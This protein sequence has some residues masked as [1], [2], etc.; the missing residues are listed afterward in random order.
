MHSAKLSEGSR[1]K[2][3]IIDLLTDFC[4]TGEAV[5]YYSAEAL[6][7][8]QFLPPS[9][10]ALAITLATLCQEGGKNSDTGVETVQCMN[11]QNQIIVYIRQP[12]LFSLVSVYYLCVLEIARHLH[13]RQIPEHIRQNVR[14]WSNL[15]GLFH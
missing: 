1:H 2:R 6:L 14:R 11:G 15:R 12:E 7:K 8:C 13:Q 5:H 3:I 9:W 4:T 10:Q